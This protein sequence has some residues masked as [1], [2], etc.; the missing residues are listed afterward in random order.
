MVTVHSG[1]SAVLGDSC[2]PDVDHFLSVGMWYAFCQSDCGTLPVSQDVV[3]IL[4]VRMPCTSCQSEIMP[5]LTAGGKG[6]PDCE[7]MCPVGTTAPVWPAFWVPSC[8][9]HFAGSACWGGSASL[10]SLRLFRM[11]TVPKEAH[12]AVRISWTTWTRWA[13]RQPAPT[14]SAIITPA[15]AQHTSLS[16]KFIRLQ[17]AGQWCYSRTGDMGTGLVGKAIHAKGLT[18]INASCCRILMLW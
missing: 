17:R 3:Y 12:V 5:C 16:S 7:D 11:C 4:S 6:L 14:Y 18:D 9:Q 8:G 2:Q 13:R 1:Q 15:T 10:F